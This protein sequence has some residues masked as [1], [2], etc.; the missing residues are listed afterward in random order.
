M[1]WGQNGSA[2]AQVQMRVDIL[3]MGVAT[4]FICHQS[5]EQML[6]EFGIGVG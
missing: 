3:S 6:S 5:L 2:A 1:G 4:W